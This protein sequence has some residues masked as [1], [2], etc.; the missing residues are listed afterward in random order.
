MSV[1]HT[2]VGDLLIS[3][4]SPGGG[5]TVRLV[6]SPVNGNDNCPGNNLRTLLDDSSSGAIVD[7][8]CTTNDPAIFGNFKPS[9]PLSA[10]NGH[11]GNGTWTLTVQDVFLQDT[12]TLNDWSLQ[13]T[14]H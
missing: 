2:Y 7:S 13:L 1:N 4:T 11:T 6:N 14:C 5:A 9:L 12:G 8:I 3:L 10:F